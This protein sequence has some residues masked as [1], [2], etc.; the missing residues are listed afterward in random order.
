MVKQCLCCLA[1]EMCM[2]R[3][4]LVHVL[5]L[6]DASLPPQQIDLDC[7]AWLAEC[8]VP[9]A[10]VFTKMDV[11]RKKKDSVPSCVQ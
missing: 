10:V 6:V 2:R 5:L 8:H 3:D 4:N 1:C 11:A 7:A 9:F